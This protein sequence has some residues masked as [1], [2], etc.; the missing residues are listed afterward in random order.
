ML[1]LDGKHHGGGL[2]LLP[3]PT[4]LGR[5]ALE[6]GGCG[7]EAGKIMVLE[8]TSHPSCHIKCTHTLRPM[9]LLQDREVEASCNE[10]NIIF[11]RHFIQCLLPFKL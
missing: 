8:A 1:E 6:S 11:C 5:E 4:P 3:V 2:L 7:Q 9:E 10:P